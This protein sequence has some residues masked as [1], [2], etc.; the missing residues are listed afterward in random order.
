MITKVE[1]K[2]E[3][4]EYLLQFQAE[5]YRKAMT[6]DLL[7]Y[8]EDQ[9]NIMTALNEFGDV[10]LCG[11]VKKIWEGRG[12]LWGVFSNVPGSYSK[13]LHQGFLEVIKN[14]DV[15]RLEMT[16]YCENKFGHKLAKSLGFKVETERLTAYRPDGGDVTMYVRI[17]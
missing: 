16:V 17:K 15:K 12:E 8:M 9:N 4:M 10:V 13:S 2:K 11:G 3:H 14:A 1:F 6:Q 5:D 7:Q